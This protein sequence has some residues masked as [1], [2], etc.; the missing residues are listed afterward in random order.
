MTQQ[1]SFQRVKIKTSARLHCG[2]FDLSDHPNR[3]YGSLGIAIDAFETALELSLNPFEAEE[4]SWANALLDKCLTQL[5]IKQKIYINVQTEIPR[6]AGLGSGTQMA[7][8]IAQGVLKL[9]QSNI[10]HEQIVASL[11]RGARSGIGIATFER[12]GVVIDGGRGANT[13]LPPILARYEFPE[14]WRA[15]LILDPNHDGLHGSQEKSAFMRLAPKSQVETHQMAHAIL[16]QA[17]P[18]LI[19]QDFNAFTQVIG[20]LQAYNA[21]YFSPAQGGDYAS[22][23]VSCVLTELK[24]EGYVGLGQSSWGATGFVL[25]PNQTAAVELLARLKNKHN[26]SDLAFLICQGNNQ[27]AKVSYPST[28]L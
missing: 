14:A 9:T 17:M 15:I 12:G 21:S 27:G 24:K 19:E 23:K 11:S 18:A 5:A 8:A 10:T 1:T 3:K 16:M 4:L 7:M 28:Q 2:F 26:T 25:C 13:L 20:Q 6:H 22:Q